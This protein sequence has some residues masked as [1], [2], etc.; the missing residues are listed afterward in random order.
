MKKEFRKWLAESEHLPEYS[1]SGSRS[2]AIDYA[3]RIGRVARNE[4]MTLEDLAVNVISV[5][6]KYERTGDNSNFGKMSHESVLNALR[7]F[8]KYTRKIQPESKPRRFSLF[9]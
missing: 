3:Y 4:N 1:I 5:L 6:S 7:Y 2:T 9:K 8:K